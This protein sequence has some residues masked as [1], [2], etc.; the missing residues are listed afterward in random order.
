MLRLSSRR[1]SPAQ[2]P[3]RFVPK[4]TF[5]RMAAPWADKLQNWHPDKH[6]HDNQDGKDN[7]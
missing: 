5:D 6:E 1:A 7:T 3:W 4:E 2:I